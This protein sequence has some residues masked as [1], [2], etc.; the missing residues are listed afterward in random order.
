MAQ[1]PPPTS[2]S[3]RTVDIEIGSAEVITIDLDELDDSPEELLELLGD[4]SAKATVWL[5]T[6]LAAEYWRQGNLD[7]A[8]KI[9]RT[10]VQCTLHVLIRRSRGSSNVS[11]L[12]CSW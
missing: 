7:A 1:S 11:R 10:A 4:G 6:K 5:W 2:A 8:D 12:Y 9:G 3:T